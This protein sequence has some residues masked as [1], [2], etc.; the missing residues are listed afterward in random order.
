MASHAAIETVTRPADW[1]AIVAYTKLP[2]GVAQHATNLAQRP[3]QAVIARS[4]AE[5]LQNIQLTN[6]AT[7]MGYLHALLPNTTI[8]DHTGHHP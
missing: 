6:C 3:A 2:A 4:L 1:A 5:L 8:D 7:N